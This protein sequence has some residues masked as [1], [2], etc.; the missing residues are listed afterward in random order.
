MN[1][2]QYDSIAVRRTE[3]QYRCK[4]DDINFKWINAES[5]QLW[6]N[7]S[8]KKQEKWLNV[9]LEDGYQLQWNVLWENPILTHLISFHVIRYMK[10]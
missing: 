1:Y 4:K 2:T 3:W 8:F 10:S 9:S 7:N 5:T 6:T